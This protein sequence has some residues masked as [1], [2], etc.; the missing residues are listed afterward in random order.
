MEIAKNRDYLNYLM[1]RTFRDPIWHELTICQ[2]VFPVELQIIFFIQRPNYSSKG[3][4]SVNP[5]HSKMTIRKLYVNLGLW[6]ME[7]EGV[8]V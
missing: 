4:W 1:N 3:K 8:A 6:V 7:G 5:R 2:D